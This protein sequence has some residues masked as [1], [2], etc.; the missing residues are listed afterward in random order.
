MLQKKKEKNSELNITSKDI[1]H[2]VVQVWLLKKI[3]LELLL[4]NALRG[5]T[6]EVG[7][8]RQTGC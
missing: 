3:V 8:Y 7:W 6:S 1:N 5:G 4:F 2:A